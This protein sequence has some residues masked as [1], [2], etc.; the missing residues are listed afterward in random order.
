MWREG[1]LKQA[2]AWA[3]YALMCQQL[4][5]FSTN[6][7]DP[8]VDNSLA[9]D[10]QSQSSNMELKLKLMQLWSMVIQLSDASGWSIV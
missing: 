8:S 1:G 10:V 7:H 2:S 3:N 4:D 6:S 9:F 5:D